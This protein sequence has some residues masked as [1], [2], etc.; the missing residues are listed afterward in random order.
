MSIREYR[1]SSGKHMYRELADYMLS[2]LSLLISNA[3]MQHIFS[4]VSY[5]KTKLKNRMSPE[6]LDSIIRTRSRLHLSGQCCQDLNVT[7]KMLE[8]FNT[9]NMYK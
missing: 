9:A 1:D 7:R 8:R 4:H 2:C 3:V 5:V 6:L